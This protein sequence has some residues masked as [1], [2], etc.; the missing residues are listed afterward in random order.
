MAIGNPFGLSH[1]VS[2][3]VISAL[4]RPFGGVPGREQNML[5]TDAAI[6]PGNSG[7]PL[8]N[9]RGEVVGINTAIYTDQARA[10]NIGIGFATPIN[11]VRDILPAL[12]NGKV[13][14][15][16]IGVSVSKDPVTKEMAQAMALPAARGALLTIVNPNGPADKAGLEPGDVIVEFN[17]RPV[18][19]SDALVG[20][21]VATK[22]G[23]TVPMTIY[24]DKQRKTV[25][26]TVDE[27]DLDAEGR[28]SRRQTGGTEEPEPTATGFGMEV[29][30]ITPEIAR[31][32]E[33]PRNRGGAVVIDVDRNSAA[34]NAGV[35]PNDVIL[36][37]NRQE[38]SNVSQVTRALQGVGSGQPVFMLLLR[39]GQEVFVTMTKR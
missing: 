3:G 8:L 25:N 32:L 31:E 1:S 35:F 37:I 12:R 10:A 9:V 39:D 34:F 26:V 17:G 2:V 36:Q 11:L 16:V 30:P 5:Q 23:T 19:N 15:G 13:T 4:G 14:R 22:P 24:R 29:G 18:E 7:G 33:L 27:L 28:L 21:V 20:M 6:N 38:V